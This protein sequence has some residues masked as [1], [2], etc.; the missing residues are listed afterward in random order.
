L[1]VNGFEPD[2]L[3]TGQ[4]RDFL[5]GWANQGGWFKVARSMGIHY[6][7]LIRWVD[8]LAEPGGNYLD[9]KRGR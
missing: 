6:V 7:T 2:K 1:M 9:Y 8:K 5:V 4:I 3:S